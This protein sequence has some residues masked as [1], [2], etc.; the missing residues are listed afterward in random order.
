MHSQENLLEVTVKDFADLF[1]TT[2][3]D[4]KNTCMD[5]IDNVDFRYRKIAGIDRDNLILDV[6][7]KLIRQK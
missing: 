2:T 1:G 5:F 3:D 7:K 6:L 4:I